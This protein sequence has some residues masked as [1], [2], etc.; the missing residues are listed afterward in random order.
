MS[1][2]LRT[3]SWPSTAY[4][5]K[6][7]TLNFLKEHYFCFASISIFCISFVNIVPFSHQNR[8][9]SFYF[10]IRSFCILFKPCKNYD[11]LVT[12]KLNFYREVEKFGII[13]KSFSNIPPLR[14]LHFVNR[15]SKSAVSFVLFYYCPYCS[16]GEIRSGFLIKWFLKDEILPRYYKKIA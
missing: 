4:I 3:P 5:Y 16:P 14:N 8:L 15:I 11:L 9:R 1:L 10:G 12:E 2:Y 6:Q 7:F 13:R